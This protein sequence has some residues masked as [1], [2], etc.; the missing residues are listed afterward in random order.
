[1][2]RCRAGVWNCSHVIVCHC[3]LLVLTSRWYHLLCV[4]FITLCALCATGIWDR[5]CWCVL[6]IDNLCVCV[7]V[8]KYCLF[9]V[10][11]I[12]KF[13]EKHSWCFPFVLR[14]CECYGRLP[15][16]SR[17][18]ATPVFCVYLCTPLGSR[19]SGSLGMLWGVVIYSCL[20]RLIIMHSNYIMQLRDREITQA[21]Q[22]VQ[23]RM[24]ATAM[25]CTLLYV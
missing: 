9:G 11:S 23:C 2:C 7:Y 16:H 10:F 24:P 21:R 14:C 20:S 22:D 18:S 13:P 6:Y 3:L 25:H 19:G 8:A 15:V 4:D 12:K 1:M 17:L 5:L